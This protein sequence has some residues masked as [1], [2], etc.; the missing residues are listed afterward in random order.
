[1][2]VTKYYW[3]DTSN[4][5]HLPRALLGLKGNLKTAAIQ[6]KKKMEN[7][8]QPSH[9]LNQ[10]NMAAVLRYRGK[11]RERRIFFLFPTGPYDNAKKFGNIGQVAISH[12]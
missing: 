10:L 7:I 11:V 1:M 2:Q 4:V 5:N 12:F 6:S 9:R 3:K 8:G